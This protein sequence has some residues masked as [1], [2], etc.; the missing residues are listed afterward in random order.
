LNS[1]QWT[2]PVLIF[3]FV[4]S[5]W[6]LTCYSSSAFTGW[7]KLS[8]RFTAEQ[9]PSGPAQSAGPFFYAVYMRWWSHYSCIVRLT[10]AEDALYLSVILPFRIGHPPLRIPWRE[11]QFGRVTFFWRRYVALTLGEQE[12][13]PLRITEGMA[14]KLGILERLPDYETAAIKSTSN[15]E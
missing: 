8:Q 6:V 9:E 5:S 11:V 14:R 10:A 13:I 3:G 7:Y 12:H 2:L 15:E 1:F 4:A